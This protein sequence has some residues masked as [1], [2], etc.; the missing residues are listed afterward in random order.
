MHL[1]LIASVGQQA[2]LAWGLDSGEKLKLCRVEYVDHLSEWV[3]TRRV[4]LSSSGEMEARECPS[5]D[6]L[7]V[8][9]MNLGHDSQAPRPCLSPHS[10]VLGA[11]LQC[12]LLR[13]G[14]GNKR[15]GQG[16]AGRS[17]QCVLFISVSPVTSTAPGTEWSSINVC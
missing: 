17:A 8:M 15:G 2:G 7:G 12:S 11:A 16:G 5:L 9:D 10:S 1:L 4:I 3:R 14:P 6:S 13:L